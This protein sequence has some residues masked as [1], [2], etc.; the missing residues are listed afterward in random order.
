MAFEY[1]VAISPS[2]GQYEFELLKLLEPNGSLD[3]CHPIVESGF[4]VT[5]ENHSG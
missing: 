4:H 5:F 3:V 1:P 2:P